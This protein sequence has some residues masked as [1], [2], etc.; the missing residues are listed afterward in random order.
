MVFDIKDVIVAMCLLSLILNPIVCSIWSNGWSD[1]PPG[2]GGHP[3]GGSRLAWRVRRASH[4]Y[5]H[6]PHFKFN[7]SILQSHN[8]SIIEP[9]VN[10]MKR[11][12]N[13]AF[14]NLAFC[15][16]LTA[17]DWSFHKMF[18]HWCFIVIKYNFQY[19]G[20]CLKD[21]IML[22]PLTLFNEWSIWADLT[23]L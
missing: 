21:N 10:P 6:H 23:D 16:S 1:L 11:W 19:L 15:I 20:M 12:N 17:S 13:Y 7:Q 18:S 3:W 8:Q 4:S 2:G 9:T 5:P 14:Y 22:W